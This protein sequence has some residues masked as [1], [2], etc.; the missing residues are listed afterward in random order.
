M[1]PKFTTIQTCFK[2]GAGSVLRSKIRSD[3]IHEESIG[4]MS[5]GRQQQQC[6]PIF[7]LCAGDFSPWNR[8]SDSAPATRLFTWV[9]YAFQVVVRLNVH[10]HSLF[11]WSSC[12]LM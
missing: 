12:F 8:W 4:G 6:R 7:F 1:F 9:D 10:F 2:S 11:L 5:S 3:L